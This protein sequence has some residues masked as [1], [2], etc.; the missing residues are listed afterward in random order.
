MEQIVGLVLDIAVLIILFVYIFKGFR[1]GFAKTIVSFL[2]TLISF[3]VAYFGSNAL[4]KIIV[5]AS[6]D[7]VLQQVRDKIGSVMTS[8][9]QTVLEDVI[10]RFPTALQRLVAGY[11]GDP[12]DVVSGLPEGL[13]VDVAQICT[14][15]IFLPIISVLLNVTLFL[16]IFF[17]C[18]FIMHKIASAFHLIRRIPILGTAD[19][20][21]GCLLGLL[22]ALVILF[23]ITTA[24]GMYMGF[25]GG[26]GFLLN[27][28]TLMESTLFEFIYARNPLC[29]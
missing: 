11:I 24:V 6:R 16:I 26:F 10:A 14:D 22:Q 21:L 19:A 17:V 13:P 12:S 29:K 23:V 9:A 1:N 2:G 20:V 25:T 5:S 28:Q 7:S 8:S 27:D 3:L 15:E 18:N 4:A